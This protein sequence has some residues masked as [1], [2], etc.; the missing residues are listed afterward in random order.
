MNILNGEREL[1]DLFRWLPE[2]LRLLLIAVHL[3]RDGGG[4]GAFLRG[5]SRNLHLPSVSLRRGGG[6]GDI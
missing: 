2:N 1:C 5:N 3:H 4:G 6:S